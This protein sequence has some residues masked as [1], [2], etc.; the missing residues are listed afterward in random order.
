M[1]DKV[2]YAP[3]NQTYEESSRNMPKDRLKNV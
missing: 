1:G 2:F 3:K